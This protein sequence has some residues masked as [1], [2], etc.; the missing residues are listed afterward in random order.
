MTEMTA[1]LPCE[2]LRYDSQRQPLAVWNER[3]ARGQVGLGA[4]YALAPLVHDL[5]LECDAAA[6]SCESTSLDVAMARLRRGSFVIL[7][8][9]FSVY[10]EIPY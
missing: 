3:V 2:P 4:V 1:R 8:S 6:R 10:M 9:K 5:L 7:P